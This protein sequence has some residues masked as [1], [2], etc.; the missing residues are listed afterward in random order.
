R[1]A[2]TTS[3]GSAGDAGASVAATGAAGAGGAV[4][5]GAGGAGG[6]GGAACAEGQ[7]CGAAPTCQ[8]EA[9]MQNVCTNGG[10][11]PIT[12]D[13][14]AYR[15][16][17]ANGTCF[18]ACAGAGVECK[19]ADSCVG[20]VCGGADGSACSVDDDCANAHCVN[21]VCCDTPC[22]GACDTNCASG[23]CGKKTEGA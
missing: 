21:S 14:G 22:D 16:N 8:N 1:A 13:C 19:A 4:Q 11:G 6:G 20:G 10:C 9:S 3:T 23:T 15:C 18:K 12:V 7:P 5:S 2:G 17:A